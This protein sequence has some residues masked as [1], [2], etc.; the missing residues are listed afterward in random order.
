M[1]TQPKPI[2]VLFVCT[3]NI[4]RSPMA[5][6]VFR[7]QVAQAG[8]Q[9]RVEADSA[10]TGAWHVGEPPHQGTRSVLR[11]RGI[12]YTHQARQVQ[13]RDFVLFDYVI[14]LDRG[15]LAELEYL[16][17]RAGATLKLLLDYAPAAGLRD[18]P[19]PYYTGGF[20]EVYEL[21]AQACQGLLDQIVERE[22]LRPERA[23][24]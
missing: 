16:A 9:G 18:V 10:G 6:A 13:P 19:D 5:E 14:A 23:A 20:D 11:A 4:C 1:P 22:Q 15:H 3:G 2:R 17:V 8:L 24:G 21:V 7:H 12:D